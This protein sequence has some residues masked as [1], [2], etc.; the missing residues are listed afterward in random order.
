MA[1]GKWDTPKPPLV[2]LAVTQHRVEEMEEGKAPTCRLLPEGSLE[3][4]RV[5]TANAS[6]PQREGQGG[7]DEGYGGQS[8]VNYGT[9][10]RQHLGVNAFRMGAVISLTPLHLFTDSQVPSWGWFSLA[11]ASAG[12]ICKFKAFS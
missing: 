8:L 11:F 2:R 5:I 7:G 6:Q 10:A 3:T 12:E 9:D 4:Q 1:P